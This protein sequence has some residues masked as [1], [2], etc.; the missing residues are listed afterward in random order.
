MTSV[1]YFQAVIR[2]T[3][4]RRL[5]PLQGNHEVVF[6]P[7]NQ[8]G[9]FDF[10]K[11]RIEILL[12]S[13]EA[14]PCLFQYRSCFVCGSYNPLSFPL[15]G[16]FDQDPLVVFVEEPAQRERERIVRYA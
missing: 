6:G 15:C 8:Y 2:K 5:C 11:N 9:T 1:K 13:A 10:R 7:G 12:R 3:L 16:F 14:L 4:K